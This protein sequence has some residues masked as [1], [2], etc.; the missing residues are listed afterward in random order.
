MNEDKTME[1]LRRTPIRA[2]IEDIE[3]KFPGKFRRMDYDELSGE[4]ADLLSA[5][6]WKYPGEFW[7]EY[8]NSVK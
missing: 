2:V 6:G 8:H 7:K 1:A 5:H 4:F 3:K